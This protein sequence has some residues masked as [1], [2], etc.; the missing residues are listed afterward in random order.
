MPPIPCTVPYSPASVAPA[1]SRCHHGNCATRP[2]RVAPL[3]ASAVPVA[4]PP[5]L[6][7]RCCLKMDRAAASPPDRRRIAHRRPDCMSCRWSPHQWLRAPR[8][9][10]RGPGAGTDPQ[11][12]RNALSHS[13]PLRQ[14]GRCILFAR[15][16]VGHPASRLGW[17]FQ[18]SP[19][20]L[21]RPDFFET[22]LVEL[23]RPGQCIF[24]RDLIFRFPCVGIR[25]PDRYLRMAVP[26]LS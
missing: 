8:V 15:S 7:R 19:A 13:G 6:R 3:F 21:A 12:V 17:S 5:S 2:S 26:L 25:R 24:Y 9:Y 14:Y 20:M 23:S 11:H 4:M 1:P 22:G 16:S 10:V 18:D